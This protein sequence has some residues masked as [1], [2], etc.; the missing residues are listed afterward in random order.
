M[1]DAF[2][3]VVRFTLK[4]GSERAFD[5]LVQ[6]TAEGIRTLEPGTLI[7]TSHKVE[8]RPSQR[9]FYELYRD[10]EAFEEHERQPH[11]RRFLQER[12]QHVAEL[13]VDR[14]NLLTG[15]GVSPDDH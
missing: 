13:E 1:A 5:Q 7:Y 14:L 8:G 10:E 11:V 4:E 15:K 3:L 9:I 6:E 2:G 12:E